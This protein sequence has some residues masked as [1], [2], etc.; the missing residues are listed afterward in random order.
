MIPPPT[1]EYLSALQTLPPEIQEI[2]LAVRAMVLEEA[3]GAFEIPYQS[4][5]AVALAFTFTGALPQTFIHTLVHKTWVS[6]AFNRGADIPDPSCILRGEAV[7]LR[8]LRLSSIPDLE[9]HFVR[10]FVQEAV[11]RAPRPA[12][13]VIT[14]PKP[15]KA[16]RKYKSNRKGSRGVVRGNRESGSKPA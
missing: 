16:K 14:E 5:N 15:P 9:R 4:P 10:R 1:P 2:A 3:L 13:V 11:S 12:E 7:N 6:L 8:Y